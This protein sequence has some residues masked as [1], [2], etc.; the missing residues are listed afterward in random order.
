MGLNEWF[1]NQK[2]AKKLGVG[3]GLIGVIFI[4]C[5]GLMQQTISSAQNSYETMFRGDQAMKNHAMSI[6][7]A[8]LEARRSEK[9]FLNRLDWKYVDKVKAAVG[10]IKQE[11]EAWKKLESGAGHS[12]DLEIVNKINAA[13]EEYISAFTQVAEAWKE[14]GLDEKSGLQGTFRN[15]AHTLEKAVGDNR[16]LMAEYLMIRRFEKDYLLRGDKKYVEQVEKAL[17]GFVAAVER[18]KFGAEQATLFKNNVTAYRGAFQEL[19]GIDGKIETLIEAMRAAVHKIEPLTEQAVE[20]TDKEMI[21]ASEETRSSIATKSRLAM[22]VA[23][24][25]LIIAVVTAMT[26]TRS[27]TVPLLDALRVNERLALGDVEMGMATDRKD[28]IGAMLGA[29]HQ[30]VENFKQTSAMAEQIALGD[31]DVH[32]RILSDKDV[33]GKSL[34][35]MVANLKKT[36]AKAEQIADGDLRVDVELLSDKDSLGKSLSSMIVKLRQV[37]TDVRAA[38]D[39]VASGSHEL[40]SSSQQVSQGASEQAAAV[41]EISASM[42]EL[43]S[44]VAQT[45]DHARQ[46]ASIATKSAADAVEGGRAVGETVSAM[47]HIAEKIELIEEIS[48]Q[49]NL[50]ALNA[51]I[52]AARAG[53]HGKGFA[54]VASEV[55]KLAERSQVSAQEIKGVASASV[56]TA[57]NA[58]K[59]IND[60]V[61]QI[62]KTAGLVQEIDAASNEQARGI[63]ENTRA[64]QQFDQVIQGNS[65]AAE[66]MA[67]TSEELTAQAATLQDTIAF[68]KVAEEGGGTHRKMA[69]PRR[70]A[71]QGK[72]IAAPK[73]KGKGDAGDK[74]VRLA[75]HEGGEAEF[76]RY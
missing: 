58:G 7:I 75:L 30:V 52:E 2:M 72:T 21:K 76:E 70:N 33:L 3:F 26:I 50:L 35:N 14:K 25:G 65:A 61:P 13:V 10:K 23:L 40:S 28:E 71:A 51:A 42:E 48:R 5:M 45:A 19:V 24:T 22:A 15:A 59:L 68:F 8:M 47:Q 16:G 31:L 60:I 20:E 12:E 69:Q 4:L 49:T 6:D 36:A 62:Q 73:G 55:R 54:V 41:E 32:V 67:A 17:S 27:I 64:I 18:E 38:S 46:T 29:M 9:D 1:N 57:T 63:E 37:I 34:A 44:T 74:G 56:E 66:E 11:A 43:A 39:Q 53:E